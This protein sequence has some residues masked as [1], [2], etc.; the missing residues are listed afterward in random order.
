[1]PA[2]LSSASAKARF[3]SSKAV[4]P[5]VIAGTLGIAHTRW[6]THGV[7]SDV[8]AHPHTDASGRLAVVHNGIIENAAELR[9]W[10]EQDGVAFRSET[11]TEVLAHLIAQRPELSLVEAVRAA[12]AEDQGRLCIG[13][14]RCGA[15]GS[16]VAARNGRPGG[17]RLGRR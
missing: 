16:H 7:P 3:G 8:N 13:G 14:D 6:A 10:L 15:A 9:R 1:M 12:L 4:L 17:D 5:G 2:P 11:D